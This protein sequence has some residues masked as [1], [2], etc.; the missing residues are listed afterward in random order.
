[1]SYDPK[2]LRP[3]DILLMVG[4]PRLTAGGALDVAI[5]WATDSPFDHACMVGD[6]HLIESLDVVTRSPL[7][8]YAANGWVY[9][10]AA[11]DPEVKAAVA[12]FDSRVGQPYGIKALLED[13]LLDIAHVPV[14]AR[15]DPRRATCSGMVAAAYLHAGVRL[16]WHPLPSPADLSFSPLLLGSRPWRRTNTGS[17]AA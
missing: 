14:Y 16:T 11:A 17:G 8:K 1:M 3:G 6:G 7:D 12:W 9:Q 4:R 15:I 13:G 10:V 2:D 5:E